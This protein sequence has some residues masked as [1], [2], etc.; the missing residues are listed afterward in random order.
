MQSYVKQWSDF[1]DSSLLDM[2][3]TMTLKLETLCAT[4][5]SVCDVLMKESRSF[6]EKTKEAQAMALAIENE[7]DSLQIEID[8]A[9]IV[10]SEEEIILKNIVSE[11]R[12]S[13]VEGARKS[14]EHV[15]R[16]RDRGTHSTRKNTKQLM[17]A[18]RDM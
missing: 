12:K 2:Q 13:A 18:L 8:A 16:D 9:A 3:T 15:K 17:L 14:I 4:A 6:D 5:D 11:R 1:V 10:Q 7:I